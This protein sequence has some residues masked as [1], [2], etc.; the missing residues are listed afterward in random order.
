MIVLHMLI[1]E[2]TRTSSWFSH[3]GMTRLIN[4]Q[5]FLK[6]LYR[7]NKAINMPIDTD[8]QLHD[9]GFAAIVVRWS[10]SRWASV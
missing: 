10:S 4:Y 8:P 3:F 5:K 7:S 6:R 1:Y 9:G 2:E